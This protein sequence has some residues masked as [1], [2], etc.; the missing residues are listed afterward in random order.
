MPDEVHTGAGDFY[1]SVM[2]HQR[3]WRFCLRI[4]TNASDVV[5]S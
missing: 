2:L 3:L 1:R 5:V 4:V